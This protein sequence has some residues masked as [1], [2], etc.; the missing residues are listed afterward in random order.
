VKTPLDE[1][2]KH[3]VREDVACALRLSATT[4]ADRLELATELTRLPATLDR[5]ERG[6]ISTHHA[7]HLGRGDRR[8]D[9]PDSH[10][11]RDRGAGQGSGAVTGHLHPRDPQSGGG[12]GPS[13]SLTS[14][15]GPRKLAPY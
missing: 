8:P 14:L 7:R 10:R 13:Q 5:L 11:G 15:P 2:D 6:E 3:W 1:L 9:R 4:A 12:R